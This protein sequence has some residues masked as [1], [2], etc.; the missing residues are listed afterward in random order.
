MVETIKIDDVEY[1]R[2]DS[3]K[4]EDI[5][6]NLKIVLLQRGWVFVGYLERNGSQCVL[7]QASNIRRWG[8]SKG[9]G[10]IAEGGPTNETK[11][12]KCYGEVEFDYLT[13]VAT[14]SCK[15]SKWKKS[16]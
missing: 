14:I 12:D 6:G 11:L 2:A 8:T 3:V 1:I 15:E 4:H 7:R 5:K 13:V 9:L 16:L 10:E